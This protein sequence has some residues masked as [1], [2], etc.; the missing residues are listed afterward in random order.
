MDYNE[1]DNYPT[2]SNAVEYNY[3]RPMSNDS[4]SASTEPFNLTSISKKQARSFVETLQTNYQPPVRRRR[5]R[6]KKQ[7]QEE[8]ISSEKSS[9]RR[10]SN[11]FPDKS[12]ILDDDIFNLDDVLKTWEAKMELQVACGFNA[13]ENLPVESVAVEVRNEKNTK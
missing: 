10:Q 9:N 2:T 1:Y 13:S 8:I 4:P 7:P 5:R 3:S 12:E 6:V 11:K